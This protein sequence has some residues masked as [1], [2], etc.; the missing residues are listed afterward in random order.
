MLD[1]RFADP[2]EEARFSSYYGS[3]YRSTYLVQTSLMICIW[4]IR[5]CHFYRADSSFQRDSLIVLAACAVIL[6]GSNIWEVKGNP[7]TCTE[8]RK[9]L[10]FIGDLTLCMVAVIWSAG[11]RPVPFT[12]GTVVHV[13]H[14][15]GSMAGGFRLSAQSL[16]HLL[17]LEAYVLLSSQ[18]L[19]GTGLHGCIKMVGGT[20]A[21][22][23]VDSVLPIMINLAYEARQRAAYIA[24]YNLDEDL[25][26]AWAYFVT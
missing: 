21:L 17:N 10:G 22:L 7:A 16:L 13:V 20:I 11:I 19:A 8:Y 23:L 15:W 3:Q 12:T 14:G 18:G 25:Q 4:V 26:A 2:L 5:A 9:A 1:L 24:K 6:H